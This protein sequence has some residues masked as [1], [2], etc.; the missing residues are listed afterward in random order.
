MSN[1]PR[2]V[3]L[4]Y[5]RADLL[6]GADLALVETE[7]GTFAD[8]EEYTLGTVYVEHG[9][10]TPRA[11]VALMDEVRSSDEARGVVVPDLRHLADG[12]HRILRRHRQ[13]FAILSVL[14][15]K[16]AP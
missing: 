12:E 2:P 15:A 14:V 8:Q 9:D 4:G 5:I 16:L 1:H 11:F 10:T 6:R 7:L 13:D 3:L